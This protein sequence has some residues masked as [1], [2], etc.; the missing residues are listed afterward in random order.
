M[1]PKE[2]AGRERIPEDEVS[3]GRADDEVVDTAI[4][5]DATDKVCHFF[6]PYVAE[7]VRL[8]LCRLLV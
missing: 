6:L 8:I 5:G 2:I 7:P 4:R 3:A 1:T